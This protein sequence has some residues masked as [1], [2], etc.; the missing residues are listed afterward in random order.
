MKVGGTRCEV[1]ERMKNRSDEL[2]IGG[3]SGIE[4]RDVKAKANEGIQNANGIT[5]VWL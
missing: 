1:V 5:T 2:R 4:T 3:L